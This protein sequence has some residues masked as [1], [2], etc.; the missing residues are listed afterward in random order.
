MA[1]ISQNSA[2]FALLIIMVM[3]G[4]YVWT[5][6]RN[7]KVALALTLVVLAIGAG[8]LSARHGPSEAATIAEVDALLGTG[9]PVVLE[10]YSDGCAICLISKHSVDD[11]ENRLEGE[12][13]VVRLD[14]QDEV[15]QAAAVRYR[16]NITPTFIVFA[17]DGSERFRYSGFPDTTRI[18]AEALNAF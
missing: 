12:V 10:V 3:L 6:R 7:R 9:Q 4:Y 16:V 17:A 15:G 11:M 18:E 14:V 5:N 2:T 8:Y 13:E 1:F